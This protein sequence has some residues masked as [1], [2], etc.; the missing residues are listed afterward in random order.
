MVASSAQQN[1]N[2][3]QMDYYSG[4]RESLEATLFVWQNNQMAQSWHQ[5]VKMNK[6]STYRG[7]KYARV[8]GNLL[9]RF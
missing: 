8:V 9:S 3:Q 4:G 2:K 1:A 5:E 6:R 7:Q